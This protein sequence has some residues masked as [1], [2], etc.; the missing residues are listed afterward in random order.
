MNHSTNRQVWWLN[1]AYVA[2]LMGV[3]VP[4]A[5]YVTPEAMFLSQ[6]RTPKYFDGY[7]LVLS[8]ALTALFA[9][10]AAASMTLAKGSAPVDW[11]R[12]LPWTWIARAFWLCVV[13]SIAGYL[14]WAGVAMVRGA[15]PGLALGVLRGEKGASYL[16][17][18]V[19]LGTI[20]GVTTLTQLGIPAMIL[21]VMLGAVNGWRKVIAPLIMLS[22][23]AVIRA[24]FNSERLAII[25][26]AIPALVI[27]LRLIVLESP[28]FHGR[29]KGILQFAPIGGAV[30]LVGIFAVFEYFR[31]WTTYYA[32]GD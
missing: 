24:L 9:F 19:Y 21:G 26:L 5:A 8:L 15:S 32:G 31:S 27:G 3:L 11:K 1:P 23:L 29:L 14:A 28:R 7:F 12:E 6:W 10:G 2:G 13:L 22:L 30:G 25:E 16:M 18:E 20:S 17:K 4:V